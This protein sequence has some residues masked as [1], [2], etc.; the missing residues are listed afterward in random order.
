MKMS[1][2]IRL[3]LL[4]DAIAD[5]ELDGQT[6]DALADDLKYAQD[7]NGTKDEALRGIKRLVISGIRREL[8]A[9]DRME[10]A[11]KRHVENC[12]G[13]KWV[14]AAAQAATEQPHGVAK[15]L[16]LLLPYRWPLAVAFFSPFSVQIFAQIAEMLKR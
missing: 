12:S 13:A 9:H 5:S 16:V 10:K 14:N 15:W 2:D 3:D 7:I 6:K 8:L 4:R 1:D 11:I